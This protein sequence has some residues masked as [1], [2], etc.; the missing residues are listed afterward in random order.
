MKFLIVEFKYKSIFKF[1]L[2]QSSSSH[3]EDYNYS[4]KR[5]I[6]SNPLTALNKYEVDNY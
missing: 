3:G 1:M 2:K 4:L 5:P 6:D